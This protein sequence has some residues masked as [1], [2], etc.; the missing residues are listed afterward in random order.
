MG[1]SMSGNNE[2]STGAHD[3]FDEL[4][5][6]FS[7]C[8]DPD[9]Q[10]AI[11]ESIWKRFGTTGAT[12]ISDMA[13]FSSTS[14]TQGICHFLKLIHR[15]RMTVA[16]IV[17]SHSG[18]LLKCDA[19]NCYAYFDRPD[20]AIRASMEINAALFEANQQLDLEDHIYLSVGIDYGDL[21]LVGNDDFYGDPVNTASKLG[22]DLATKAETLVTDRALARSSF[23]AHDNAERMVARVSDIKIN[24]V[25]FTMAEANFDDGR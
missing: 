24:Y 22:E 6:A 25:R 21:L 11:R 9:K 16:P 20:D 17:A 23:E 1:T 13:N 7:A 3:E 14:R 12:F 8:T 4:I 5:A 2:S 15:A 10:S 19:D 18:T